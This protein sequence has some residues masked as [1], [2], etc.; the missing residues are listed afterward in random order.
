MFFL[1]ALSLTLLYNLCFKLNFLHLHL[2]L[3]L[4]NCLS[5]RSQHMGLVH[6]T[7]TILQISNY[8]LAQ[9]K[10][11]N[12]K[13]SYH[14]FSVPPLTNGSLKIQFFKIVS[15]HSD[16]SWIYFSSTDRIP[17]IKR[18]FWAVKIIRQSSASATLPLPPLTITDHEKM[19]ESTK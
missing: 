2:F 14:L 11:E 12:F 16:K 13:S 3:P 6:Q 4:F 17:V 9:P 7:T 19:A 15:P 18:R 10:I 1:P 8:L 5:N